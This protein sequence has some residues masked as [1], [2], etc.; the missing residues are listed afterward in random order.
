MSIFKIR[1]ISSAT[2]KAKF[3]FPGK[4]APRLEES[5]DS[6]HGSDGLV[7]LLGEG[8]CLS[9]THMRGEKWVWTGQSEQEAHLNCSCSPQMALVLLIRRPL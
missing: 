9:C 2:V 1:T 6:G 3:C 8:S 7:V 4:Q 5:G